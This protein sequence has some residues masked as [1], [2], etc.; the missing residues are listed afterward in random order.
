MVTEQYRWQ[1]AMGTIAGSLLADTL[2]ATPR[3][4]TVRAIRSLD[5]AEALV[6][7]EPVP[8]DLA[9]DVAVP[10]SMGLALRGAPLLM[11][12]T[13]VALIDLVGRALDGVE[14]LAS[15][16]PLLSKAIEL[17]RSTTFVD[18]I[19]GAG[20]EPELASLV[21]ALVGLRGGLGAIPARLVST[22]SA[23]DGTRGRRYLRGLTN[24]LLGI[25]LPNWYDPRRRRGPKEVLPGLWL[26][27]LYGISAFVDSYPD[28]L[29]LSLCDEEGRLADH[30]HH[31]TFHLEDAPR[32]DANPSLDFVIDDV[33]GE[34][35]AA[36]QTGQ[37]VLVHCR[38]GAS[39][40]GLILR[41]LLVQ[42]LGI[43][44]E[45]ALVEAQCHWSHTSTWNR[46]WTRAVERRAAG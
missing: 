13:T 4:W 41:I 15:A 40:T 17:S 46:D 24:R 10:A 14:P 23:S 42:E 29:V 18:A 5:I 37:P 1:A 31:I 3:A 25:D 39:R 32:S 6:A 22:I 30:G 8:V 2:T 43:S 26:S 9:P 45:D 28:G 21:G 7:G 36:R 35:A 19:E 16:D 33:I 11:D 34:I 20:G 44:A 38:H 12:S 27:N